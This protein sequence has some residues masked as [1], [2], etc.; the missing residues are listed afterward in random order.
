ML[1][2]SYRM[3]GSNPGQ[4]RAR[5]ASSPTALFPLAP[6]LSTLAWGPHL[7]HARA[8]PGP[9]GARV[10][11]GARE[12]EGH[13]GHFESGGVMESSRAKQQWDSSSKGTPGTGEW[14]GHS[15]PQKLERAIP[16]HPEKRVCRNP[17]SRGPSCGPYLWGSGPQE[18]LYFDFLV[19]GPHTAVLRGPCKIPGI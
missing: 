17:K 6:T 3:L 10:Q 12:P 13:R 7:P 1:S 19:L 5:K 9:G 18:I 16:G 2:R 14:S 15:T 4:P 11:L 8:G